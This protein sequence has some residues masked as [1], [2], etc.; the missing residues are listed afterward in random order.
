MGDNRHSDVRGIPVASP[1]TPPSFSFFSGSLRKLSSLDGR[2]GEQAHVQVSP[3]ASP[4]LA[5]ELAFQTW[6]YC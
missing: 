4:Q 6:R 2:H 3:W 1:A 5:I